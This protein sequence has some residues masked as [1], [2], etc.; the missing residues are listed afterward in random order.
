MTQWRLSALK[1]PS[2]QFF[3]AFEADQLVGYIEICRDWKNDADRFY[4]TSV[5]IM[6]SHQK[7]MRVEID[8]ETLFRNKLFLKLSK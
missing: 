4:I 3:G 2:T 6:P 7:S 5:Q 1:L 8:S